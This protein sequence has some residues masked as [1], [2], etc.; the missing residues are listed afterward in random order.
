M[1]AEGISGDGQKVAING[2]NREVFSPNDGFQQVAAYWTQ[3]TGLTRL[4][5]LSSAPVNGTELTYSRAVGISRD[6]STIFGESRGNDGFVQAAYWRGNNVF[7]LGY[8]TGVTLPTERSAFANGSTR[9]LAANL[10]GTIIVGKSFGTI[11]NQ[12]DIAWR[13]T[14]TS[15]M[16]DLNIFAQNAGINLNGYK[17]T[18]AVGLSDKGQFITGNAFNSALN[19]STGYVLQIAQITNSRLIV[20]MRLSNV[21]LSAIINQTF[22]TQID[23]TLNGTNVFTRTF[24]DAINSTTG[25]T[26][27]NDANAALSGTTGLR[28]LNI[29][30][31]ILVSSNTIVLGTTNNTIDVL[32]GTITNTATVNTF[33]PA[34]VATGDLGVCATA[35]SNN[36]NPTGCSLTGTLVNVDN[37]VLNSNVFTNTINTIT[38]TT[39][40]TINQLINAKWKIEAIA[41]NQFGTVHALVAPVG[42]SQSDRLFTQLF[43]NNGMINSSKNIVKGDNGIT[44]FGSYLGNSSKIDADINVGTAQ[45]KGNSNSL[46]FGAKKQI[47]PNAW[48]GAAID[49]GSSEFDVKD[50][51]FPENLSLKQTLFAI[52]GGMQNGKILINGGLSFGLGNAE[53]NISTPTGYA[54]ATRDFNSLSAGAQ[55]SFS[56]LEDKNIDL[57]LIGGA[58]ANSAKLDNFTESGGSNPIIGLKKDVNAN[59]IYAGISG[60]ARSKIGQLQFYA[61]GAQN[62]GD[63]R[64]IAD[65]KLALDQT[66]AT[67]QAF[68]PQTGKTA[69][70]IG[71]YLSKDLNPKTR[72]SIGYDG[73]FTKHS[74]TN[75]AKIGIS[76]KW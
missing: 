51:A 13:W 37:G 39:T 21:T 26:A 20:N 63:Y 71:L 66:G 5:D 76:L 50:N 2:L 11:L 16:Q 43:S 59:K 33:G 25:T 55:I 24:T 17:L 69:T 68:A 8:L 10:D 12:N 74:Q 53:T 49:H 61:R 27:L 15:G 18:E 44:L 57:A 38:P 32:T 22:N 54:N 60:E 19:K 72:I 70:E 48:L 9:A 64:G 23:A 7:G 52:S 47:S 6:G 31:P 1:F 41:G 56:L 28:R 65:V 40:P 35:A 46:V 75:N 14:A 45:I 4:V 36:Q 42:F 34:T 73:S 67:L 30:A 29:G 3:S 62:S 58:I